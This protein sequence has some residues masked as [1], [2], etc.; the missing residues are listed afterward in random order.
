MKKISCSVT[1]PEGF[2]AS[3]IKSG[4]K[5]NKLDLGLIFSKV[6]ARAVGVFT[7]NEI[8][9]APVEVCQKNLKNGQAQAII[10]NSGN[11][12]CLCGKK[13]FNQAVSITKHLSSCLAIRTEDVLIAS[14]GVI[15]KPF[16][17]DKI[18][19]AL[20]RLVNKLSR[21]GALAA[22]K[23]IMTTDL[24]LK[25]VAVKMKIGAKE[26]KLGGIAKGSG[27]IYPNMVSAGDS[28][29][30]TMLCFLTTDACI[31]QN[32]LTKSLSDAV[33][34]S[35][36]AITVDGDMSTNDTVIILANSLSGNP[37]I[38]YRS[39]NYKIFQ[40]ALKYVASYLAKEIVRD[41]EGASKFIEIE[42]KGAK[43]KTDAQKIASRIANSNLVKTAIAGEDPNVGRIAAAAGAAGVRLDV[44]KLDIYL[45]G[46]KI[47]SAGQIH[48]QVRTKARRL[49]QNKKI[50]IL[51]NLNAGANRASIWTC[52]LTEG[53]IKINAKYN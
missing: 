13:G 34:E 18:I 5:D 38:K 36:N 53:Y 32:A 25:Q 2:L 1:A 37:E 19:S 4:I 10:V 42:I 30:A 27:M 26:V 43:S 17:A 39:R 29:G 50:K 15:G 21:S 7:K 48:Y 41:G 6:P 23:A 35:F 20:P 40:S 28:F 51:L 9:A 22:A 47:M 3:G 49:L 14:T 31:E 16:P 11:A 24:F 52:D 45:S 46:L 12:N 44:P 33:D 8:K